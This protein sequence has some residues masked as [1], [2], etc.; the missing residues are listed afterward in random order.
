MNPDRVLDSFL[1]MVVVESPSWHEAPMAAYCAGKLAEMGFSVTFDA[2]A[3]ETGSDTG[4]LIAH[5]PGTVPGRVAFSAHLD[6]V[7]PCAGI[8]PVIERRHIC[9]DVT[10]RMAEVVCSAGDTIL[11]ADDKAGIAAIFEGVRATL[12]DGAARPDI[13][14]LLTT[15]E[16]QSLLGSSALAEDALVWPDDVPAASRGTEYEALLNA[17]GAGGALPLFVLDADGAPGSLIMGAPYHW[18]L[19]ARIH[20][21]AAHAG[22]EPECGVSAIQIASAA[23]AA[24]PLG[25]IDECTTANVGRI[26]GGVAVNIVPA[27]V[28]L[29]G[30]CR[31][32]YE[33][34]V[35]AQRDAMT[36]AL[37]ETASQLG[38][39]AE[40]AWELDYPAVVHEPGD[41][42]V[43]HLEAAAAACG[44]ATRHAISGG[45]AD[46][47]VLGTKGADAITL[48]IGMAN[49]HSVDEYILVEDLQNM[50]RYVEAIIAEYAA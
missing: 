50:A 37:E 29:E 28:T 40:V 18:T 35:L 9:D 21:R 31:S 49:F 17:A 5:L 46:A 16:E 33:D 15:C 39:T 45:G 11:S 36:R 30:E 12:E 25:R 47:N 3:A 1:E 34:R 42:L 48:G 32:L 41:A 22:V 26:E 43:A 8:E 2:S 6:T 44:L 20:G 27:A 24:M 14:V 10:C 19:R 23:V 4:N 7:K 38:G 13:T